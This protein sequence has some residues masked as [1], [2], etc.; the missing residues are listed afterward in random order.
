MSTLFLYVNNASTTNASNVLITDTTV[1]LQTGTGSEFPSPG[2]GQQAAITMEDTSGNIEVMYCTGRSS[3]TLTV[4]R[5]QEGTPARAFP[6]GSRVEMRITEGMLGVLLQKAGGDTLTGTTNLSGVLALGGAGSIQ[7]GEFTGALRGAPGQTL[8]QIIVANGG[9]TATQNGSIILTT[10]N[11][12]ANL[13]SGTDL[14]HTGMILLWSGSTGT[15]PGG[16]H[17]CDGTNG[18]PDLR[19]SFVI[20]AGGAY[21]VGATG[22]STPGNTG[23]TDPVTVNS[24]A[25]AGHALTVNEMPSHAH[26]I[27]SASEFSGSSFSFPNYAG[28]TGGAF[29]NTNPGAGGALIQTTGGASGTGGAAGNGVAHTHSFTNSLPHVHSYTLPPYYALCYIMKL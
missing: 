21:A 19:G 5:A 22:G 20:G 9:S 18:T 23:S 2:A 12:L 6:S 27:Y 26:N 13:P 15:I 4:V 7:G 16:W 28:A 25:V 3:D 1:V 8:G 29:T 24:F 14:A 11:I 17:L 10:A